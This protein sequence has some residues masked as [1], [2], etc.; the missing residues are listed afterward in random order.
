MAK[1][2]GAVRS[3]RARNVGTFSLKPFT[4]SDLL[5]LASAPKAKRNGRVRLREGRGYSRTQS[6]VGCEEQVAGD[7]EVTC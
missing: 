6:P 3:P 4:L 7:H 1:R 5:S 2:Y